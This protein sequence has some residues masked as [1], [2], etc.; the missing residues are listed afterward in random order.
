MSR[1][2]REPIDPRPLAK[3]VLLAQWA[4]LAGEAGMG[5]ASAREA[6]RALNGAP[7]PSDAAL[8]WEGLIA[9]GYLAAYVVAAFLTLKWIYRV[10]LNA[11]LL[12]S[13]KTIRPA[14]AVGW[15]F[16]PFA[17]LVMPFRAMRETWQISHSP[18]NWKDA[19]TPDL[20]GW[21]WGFFLLT[22]FLGTTA[23]RIELGTDDPGVLLLSD[24]LSFASSVLAIPLVLTLRKIV[25][26]ITEAQ[27]QAMRLQPFDEPPE[28][29]P[30][31][32]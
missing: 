8:L 28:P 3:T 31:V 17:S 9:V 22:G 6:G 1:K 19:P 13:G 23:A 15:Y 12:A 16:V 2:T 25:E 29:S 26:R 14:W 20:L 27:A 21:W 11:S 5:L 24:E 7:E 4:Y 32:G 30:A 10:N 18:G